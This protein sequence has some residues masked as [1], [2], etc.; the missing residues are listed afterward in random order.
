MTSQWQVEIEDAGQ[1]AQTSRGFPARV[2]AAI[3]IAAVLVLVDAS[4]QITPEAE[5]AEQDRPSACGADAVARAQRE[6]LHRAPATTR[7]S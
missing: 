5:R 2:A 4:P 6:L 7:H 3:V 1:V